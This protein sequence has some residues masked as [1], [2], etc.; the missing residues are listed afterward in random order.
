MF[1]LMFLPKKG[2][3]IAFTRRFGVAVIT[4]TITMTTM[5]LADII[6]DIIID[7]GLGL[8]IPLI[9]VRAAGIGH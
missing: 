1:L 4:M 3:N 6:L 8:F 9:L 5:D 2:R 7:F